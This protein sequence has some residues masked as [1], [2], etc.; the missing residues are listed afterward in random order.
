MVLIPVG[1]VS[2]DL[3]VWLANR[4]SAV[5][6]QQVTV[7]DGIPLPDGAYDPRRRH[8]LREAILDALRGVPHIRTTRV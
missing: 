6:R 8:Y 5:L 1:P 4:L 2:A 7:G 3:T